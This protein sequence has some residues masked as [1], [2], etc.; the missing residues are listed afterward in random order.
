MTLRHQ[1][2]AEMSPGCPCSVTCPCQIRRVLKKVNRQ[3]HLSLYEENLPPS[4]EWKAEFACWCFLRLSTGRG[5][6]LRAG[7]VIELDEGDALIVVPHRPGTFRASQLGDATLSFFLFCPELLPGLLTLDELRQL[8]LLPSRKKPVARRFRPGDPLA[9]TFLRLQAQVA[10]RQ[11]LLARCLML[12]IAALFF[13]R[14]CRQTR[15]PGKTFMPAN[16]R[17]RLLLQQLPEAE[18]LECSVTELAARCNCG[19]R[20]FNRLF[21]QNVGVSFRAKQAEIRMIKAKQMLA[22][23]SEKIATVA[24]AVGYRHP[25]I[26]NTTFKK[27]FGTSPSEWRKRLGN[28]ANPCA[29]GDEPASPAN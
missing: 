28:R 20:H 15:T 2:V 24:L 7:E 25:G 13:D 18:I 11:G 21:I 17:I 19:P 26:F 29:V 6:W 22:E 12:Q 14:E 4:G 9:D 16:K 10:Q 23:T 27:Q 3:S 1:L 8:E 5:Y